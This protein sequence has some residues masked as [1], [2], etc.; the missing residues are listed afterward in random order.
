M[1]TV[2]RAGPELTSLSGNGR[3]A[4]IDHQH[5]DAETMNIVAAKL[6]KQ[7]VKGQ[8]ARLDELLE[9]HPEWTGSLVQL[10]ETGLIDSLLAGSTN[11]LPACVTKYSLL[12]KHVMDRCILALKCPQ[13]TK[14]SLKRANR[15][16]NGSSAKIFEFI[17]AH[18]AADPIDDHE[19]DSFVEEEVLRA[20]AVGNRAEQIEIQEDGSIDW[21]DKG[22]YSIVAPQGDDEDGEHQ[23]KHK[24]SNICVPLPDGISVK[25][26]KSKLE[27]K[28]NQSDYKAVLQLSKHV[29]VPLGELFQGRLNVFENVVELKKAKYCLQMDNKDQASTA[30]AP[31]RSSTDRTANSSSPAAAASDSSA[32]RRRQSLRG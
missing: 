17:F 10:C 16:A 2:I 20:D 14:A 21:N 30:P 26:L 18:R 13:L 4:E 31:A 9:E 12:P 11:V 19:L 1:L 24:F 22:V 25:N 32:K 5:G 8:K 3:P 15:K 7:G 6:E 27:I 23:V 28:D 29:Q